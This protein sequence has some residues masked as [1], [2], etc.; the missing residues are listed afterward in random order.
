M[1]LLSTNITLNNTNMPLFNNSHHKT[2]YNS[3]SDSLMQ[4]EPNMML[5]W[6]KS[7]F[8]SSKSPTRFPDMKISASDPSTAIMG[9]MLSND[10]SV[11]V[12]TCASIILILASVFCA[13]TRRVYPDYD[14]TEND[15]GMLDNC[16]NIQNKKR[17]L[18]VDKERDICKNMQNNRSSYVR[19]KQVCCVDKKNKMNLPKTGLAKCIECLVQRVLKVS[20]ILSIGSII[21]LTNYSSFWMIMRGDIRTFYDVYT[22]ELMDFRVSI[23]VGLRGF[24]ITLSSLTYNN[25]KRSD[26]NQTLNFTESKDSQD[27]YLFQFLNNTIISDINHDIQFDFRK[28]NYSRAHPAFSAAS[29][30]AY[31]SSTLYYNSQTMYDVALKYRQ[32]PHNITNLTYIKNN[33]LK[34]IRRKNN[35][36]FD[37]NKESSII[38]VNTSAIYFVPTK[39]LT[40]EKI[41]REAIQFRNN[42][43]KLNSIITK[44]PREIIRKNPIS[45]SESILKRSVFKIE[46]SFKDNDDPRV[47]STLST[48]T[49]DIHFNERFYWKDGDR[50][51][52]F[53][54]YKKRGLPLPIMDLAECILYNAKTLKMGGYYTSYFSW[55][56]FTFWAMSLILFNV[57]LTAGGYSLMLTGIFVLIK[58]RMYYIYSESI[59]RQ[60]IRLNSYD[61]VASKLK[62]LEPLKLSLGP[63]FWVNLIGGSLAL[64]AGLYVVMV[65]KLGSL[66]MGS[67]LFNKDRVRASFRRLK[68][69]IEREESSIEEMSNDIGKTKSNG[70]E[71]RIGFSNNRASIKDE[72]SQIFGIGANSSN[73][74]YLDNYKKVNKR[75]NRRKSWDGKR[76]LVKSVHDFDGNKILSKNSKRKSMQIIHTSGTYPTVLTDSN[77]SQNKRHSVL[78]LA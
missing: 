54:Y 47:K 46:Q 39:N 59:T 33:S 53:L 24:N 68:H 71:M 57:M 48:K 17:I 29:T 14:S 44:S 4:D 5:R 2:I 11:T 36:A 9:G 62:P 20:F 76:S 52:D 16:D 45:R 38:N 63:C 23:Y 7:V 26:S 21:L 35:F 22:N 10:F 8:C 75:F 51:T 70:F 49:M 40:Q 3:A 6:F 34:F 55:W 50:S 32:L 19:N 31:N 27:K 30:S 56:A 73:F 72:R 61:Y 67:V 13:V 25:V 64:L 77:E 12:L 1:L 60:Y 78:Y 69:E 74:N 42:F 28:I 66:Q 43:F 65:V 58:I 18:K 15:D 41:D 37:Y